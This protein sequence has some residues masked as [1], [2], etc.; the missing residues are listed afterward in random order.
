[1]LDGHL[2]RVWCVTQPPVSISSG[3]SEFYAIVKA[4]IELLYFSFLDA[5]RGERESELYTCGRANQVGTGARVKH[6][7]A[8][9]HIVQQ[10]L[11]VVTLQSWQCLVLQSQRRLARSTG[12]QTR[13]SGSSR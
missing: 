6:V 12:R 3:E 10:H 11:R 2:I 7:A 13:R 8:S 1:M 4:V 9:H 5:M